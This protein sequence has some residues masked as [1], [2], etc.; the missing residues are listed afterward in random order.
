MTHTLLALCLLAPTATAQEI[1]PQAPPSPQ[2][3]VLFNR[4][5]E[6]EQ[7]QPTN[8]SEAVSKETVKIPDAE[9][10]SL[11]FT[12]YDL[13]AHVIPASSQLAVHARFGVRNS[14]AAPLDRLALQLSSTLRW[15]NLA[16]ATSAGVQPLKFVQQIIHTDADHT[17]EATEA[18]ITLPHPFAPGD[19]LDLTAIYS[20]PIEFSARRLDVID[21]PPSQAA[22]TD[23]DA[24]TPEVSGLRGFG[25]VLWYPTASAPLFLGDGAKLFQSVG[26]TK[27]QQASTPIHLRLTVEYVGDAPKD[28]YFNGQREPLLSITENPDTPVADAPG[29]ATADF[30]SQPLGFRIPSLFLTDR[31]ATPASNHLITTITGRTEAIPAYTGAADTIQPLLADWLGAAPL[32]SLTILDHEGQPFE[33]GAFLVTDMRAVDANTIVP[34]L[35]HSLTHAWFRSS[36]AWLNEGVP[37]FMS[38]LWISRTQ[39]RDAAIQ[40]LQQLRIP[41]SLA[42]P[43]GSQ[44]SDSAASSSNPQSTSEGQSLIQAKDELY[45]RNK[46]AA[47]LWMLRSVVGDEAL[48]QAL[49]LYRRSGEADADPHHFQRVVEQASKKDLNW[50]FNDWVYQDR[51]LADL[52]IASVTPRELP[53]QGNKAASWLIAVEVRNDGEATADVPV[54]V[55]SGTLTATQR[56][57]VP[58]H[59][60]ASTRIVFEGTPDEILLN[61]GSVPETT[62]AIHSR[63]VVTHEQ[64][65]GK[66]LP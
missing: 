36:H 8:Q 10:D 54:T 43:S 60:S 15:E 34:P 56:V 44:I 47:V 11:V 4:N 58:G 26:R 3:T 19:T 27:L 6:T 28:A 32:T 12:A 17:G 66:P 65:P 64:A 1:Q 39:G 38:L 41:L 51:G 33:D 61:D 55:R 49:Q 53:A 45:Y 42:E 57:R 13:D 40:Q 21:A 5:Q 52:S 16:L 25:N 50:F 29:I 23:W 62:T 37:Q 7:K 63:Q 14:G 18:V 48:K 22:R 24:I 2:G 31:V 9:R 35:V 46:A 30:A 20:G 59:S